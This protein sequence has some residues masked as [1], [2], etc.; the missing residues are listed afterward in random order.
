M[1]ERFGHLVAPYI[2]RFVNWVLELFGFN[3][4]TGDTFYDA[5]HFFIYDTVKIIFLLSFMIFIITYIRSY[6]PPEKVKALLAK[7]H[8]IWAYVIASMLGVV[9]PFCSCSTVPIF[10]GFVEAGIPLG[11][12]FTFLVTS[13]IVNEI[14]LGYLFVSFGPKIA[15]LYTLAGMAIGIVTG[16]VIEK[17]N[18]YHL[19]EEYVFKIKI[20]E[21]AVEEMTK[22]QRLIYAK[23]SVVDIVKDIWIYVVIGIGIGALIHGWAPEELLAKY[24]GPNNP[25]AVFV[26]VL[27]GIPLYSNAV[28][29]I[30]IAEALINKGVGV[31]TALAF[32]MSV[33]ALSLPSII[34]LKKVIKPKLIGIFVGITGIG[35][36][37]VGFLFNWIL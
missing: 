24:A 31:G 32:M 36:V 4:Q 23:D 37:L 28:G 2:V 3:V 6:F 29:T 1:F 20:G 14:A 35:I 10:I 21:T 8:G 25:L 30:P 7:F 22:K 17:F 15:I 27:F 11:V 33:V 9:S 13:P 26:G 12:T 16:L 34:L 5:V 19:V 18:L